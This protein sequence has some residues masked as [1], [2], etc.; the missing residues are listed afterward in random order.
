MNEKSIDVFISYSHDSE[1]HKEWVAKLASDID[2][3]SEFRVSYD[4]FDLNSASDKNAF[5]DRA[6]SEAD[7]ILTIC[8][9]EYVFK[10]NDRRDGVGIETEFIQNRQFNKSKQ[11]VRIIAVLRNGSKLPTYLDSRIFHSFNNDAEYAAELTKLIKEIAGQPKRERPSQKKSFQV[12]AF[13]FTR[14]EDLLKLTHNKR[15]LLF[16]P[17]ERKDFSGGLKIDFE[18]W[19]TKSPSSQFYFYISNNA[20]IS[21]SVKRLAELIAENNL[22]IREIICLRPRKSQGNILQDTFKKNGLKFRIYEYS[23]SDYFW[24][25]CVDDATKDYKPEP[26]PEAF[27]EQPLIQR[28]NNRE[29][30]I[31]NAHD[32]LTKRL[33]QPDEFAAK[34]VVAPGGTGKTTLCLKLMLWMI[35][36]RC[37]IPLM[38]QAEELRQSGITQRTSEVPLNSIYDLY[39]LYVQASHIN[40]NDCI[41]LDRSNF[42]VAVITG[43]IFL[44]IDG[45]DEIISLFPETFD[46]SAFMGSLV[47]LNDQLAENRVIITTRD[48]VFEHLDESIMERFEQYYL[49]GFDADICERYFKKR[50]KSLDEAEKLER[51]AMAMVEPLLQQDFHGT[52]FP[53]V[54]DCIATVFE[55]SIEEGEAPNLLFSMQGK[56]YPSNEEVK[57]FLVYSVLRREKERQ[58]LDLDVGDIVDVLCEIVT[59]KHETFSFEE[60]EQHVSIV[61]AS[62]PKENARK[63][64]LNP[65]IV[66]EGGVFKFRYAFLANYFRY[67][68][69]IAGL[70]KGVAAADLIE[71]MAMHCYGNND[72]VNEAARFYLDKTD[73]FTQCAKA[74]IDD[75]RVKLDRDECLAE[76]SI[77]FRAIGFLTHLIAKMPG[78]AASKGKFR[79][80]VVAIFGGPGAIQEFAVYGD[81]PSIDFQGLEIKK[82]RFVRWQSI[83]SSSLKNAA[84]KECYF[85]DCASSLANEDFAQVKFQDCRLGDLDQLI[86]SAQGSQEYARGLIEQELRLFLSSFV[87]GGSFIDKKEQFMRFS[88]KVSRINK[89]F[90]KWLKKEG[91]LEIVTQKPSGTHYGI[92]RKYQSSVKRFLQN[93]FV[94]RKITLMIEYLSQ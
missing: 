94:D 41:R 82:A 68:R 22:H 16:R 21:H 15:K 20:T 13:H 44:V 80:Y 39:Q 28:K 23:L 86:K 63:L 19:E 50:F 88:Q 84:F 55:D 56:P 74:F 73:E 8:T 69:V 5:M 77:R 30:V 91:V 42:E 17:E 31:K 43:R 6:I 12:S 79:E 58:Q 25:Y 36:E 76:R 29:I 40:G 64:S 34:V 89:N 83:A 11:P 2:E 53:C 61:T 67:L 26:P 66:N 54:V 27:I 35:E 93:N 3:Y 49:R 4:E 51:K 59:R 14:V 47:Q 24:E 10:A 72:V 62:D 92:T 71:M 90:F 52:I 78:V 60:I 65:L 33:G 45:L 48:S 32:E 87:K 75:M 85:R 7:V 9:P 38:V 46:L 37:A 1:E 18:F 57:D 81:V 70:R